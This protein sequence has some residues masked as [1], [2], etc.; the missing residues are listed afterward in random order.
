[1]LLPGPQFLLC[2]CILSHLLRGPEGGAADVLLYSSQQWPGLASWVGF[3]EGEGEMGSASFCTDSWSRIIR[4]GNTDLL[5]CLEF[6]PLQTPLTSNDPETRLSREHASLPSGLCHSGWHM[7]T[8]RPEHIGPSCRQACCD[9][10]C[11]PAEDV[12]GNGKM[13]RAGDTENEAVFFHIVFPSLVSS[14]G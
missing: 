11:E 10:P 7:S 3:A 6:G 2:S 13:K 9:R 8:R 5:I 4:T 14:L 1:M 12:L